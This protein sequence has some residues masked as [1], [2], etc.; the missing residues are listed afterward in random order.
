LKKLLSFCWR[1]WH[2]II[3]FYVCNRNFILTILILR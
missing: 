1:Y 3:P 2:L